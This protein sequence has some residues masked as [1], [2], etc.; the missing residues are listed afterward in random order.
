MKVS[1]RGALEDEATEKVGQQKSQYL[2]QTVGLMFLETPHL[3]GH[4][5]IALANGVN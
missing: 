3:I 2:E 5:P 1:A 4:F